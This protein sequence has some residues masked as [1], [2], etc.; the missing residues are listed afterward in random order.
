MKKHSK[1]YILAERKSSFSEVWTNSDEFAYVIFETMNDRG[2]SL[3]Q[4]EMVRSYLLANIEERYRLKAMKS[5]DEIIR[6]L[7]NIKLTSKS[8]AEF[9]FLRYILEVIM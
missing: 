1:F 5:F 7:M 3:T 8:K 6:K 2:L 9:E 4:V